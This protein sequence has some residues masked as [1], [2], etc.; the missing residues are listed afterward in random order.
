MQNSFY[1]LNGFWAIFNFS[2][3]AKNIADFTA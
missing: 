2:D 3:L 1:I